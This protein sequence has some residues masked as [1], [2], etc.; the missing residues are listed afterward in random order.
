MFHLVQCLEVQSKDSLANDGNTSITPSKDS[1]IN[2]G[3]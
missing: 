1:D 3:I 2:V